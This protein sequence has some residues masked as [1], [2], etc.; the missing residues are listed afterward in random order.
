MGPGEP[1]GEDAS[2]R[3]PT[4][5]WLAGRLRQQG[6]AGGGQA[7]AEG[8]HA[9]SAADPVQERS[10]AS[11]GVLRSLHCDL[12]WLPCVPW[13]GDK[14]SQ[15]KRLVSIV[16]FSRA[17]PSSGWLRLS[18][19]VLL[20]RI[21]PPC[22]RRPGPGLFPGG[23]GAARGDPL[24]VKTPFLGNSVFQLPWPLLSCPF[25]LPCSRVCRSQPKSAGGYMVAFPHPAGTS[26]ADPCSVASVPETHRRA[27]HRL[28]PT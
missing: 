13:V 8:G 27:R 25:F 17:R 19:A 26:P 18:M 16:L 6:T 4:S 7:A 15:G 10:P 23:A 12:F 24:C 5:P 14:Q 22:A 21:F 3:P 28:P 11:T 9:A 1:P 2:S 20:L